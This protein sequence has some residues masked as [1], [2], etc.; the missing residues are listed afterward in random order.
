MNV[1]R[2]DWLKTTTAGVAVFTLPLCG[3]G[4]GGISS[5]P[6]LVWGRH[7]L[8]DGKLHRPRAIAIRQDENGNDELFIVDMTGRIQVFD[9]TGK[10]LRKWNTPAITNGKP[11]G[12][13]FD[14]DGD[15]LVADTHYFQMLVYSPDGKRQKQKEIGGECG[16]ELGQF[17]FVTDAVQDKEG[18]FFISHYG[19]VDRVQKFSPKGEPLLGWGSHGESLGQFIRPQ[20]MDV[21]E[22][23]QLWIADACNHRVQIYDTSSGKEELV[24]SWGTEGEAV[25]QLRYPYDIC[26]DPDGDHVFLCE[27]GNQRVQKFTRD[28][29]IVA[30][31]GKPGRGEGEFHQPWAAAI[32]SQRRLHVLDTYNHRVQQFAA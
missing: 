2:R 8:S 5:K 22:L 17:E 31:W 6:T 14:N 7:G 21:D 29:T 23:N 27:F 3:C 1:S 32:D 24:T 13:S 10:F 4:D 26:L 25:G 28:G 18:C 19:E 20:A 9:A 15:L 30:T 12:M 11:S 16:L